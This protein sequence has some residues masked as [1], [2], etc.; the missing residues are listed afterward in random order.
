VK[1]VLKSLLLAFMG[2]GMLFFFLMMAV[3]PI[4][5]VLARMGGDVSQKSVVVNPGIFLRSVGLPIAIVAFVALFGIS[6]YR[7]HRVER[8]HLLHQ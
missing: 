2:T 6:M 7:F 5:A 1:S 3:V 8:E 4:M